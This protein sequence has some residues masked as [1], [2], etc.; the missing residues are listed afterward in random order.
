MSAIKNDRY[1]FV[2]INGNIS[3]IARDYYG[4]IK[5]ASAMDLC[6]LSGNS[7]MV[8]AAGQYEQWLKTSHF[9]KYG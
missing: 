2:Y 8:F 4:Y 5:N 3:E 9:L 6:F 7:I 1:E